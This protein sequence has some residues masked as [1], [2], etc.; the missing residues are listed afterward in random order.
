MSANS[1]HIGIAGS[2][3]NPL[4]DIFHLPDRVAGKT[5]GRAPEVVVFPLHTVDMK[6]STTMNSSAIDCLL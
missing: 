6:A 3:F 5:Y 4:C 1:L 2:V